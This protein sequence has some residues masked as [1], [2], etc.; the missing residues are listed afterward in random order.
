[1]IL[2]PFVSHLFAIQGL[3][4]VSECRKQCNNLSEH[5]RNKE[6]EYL[7]DKI[8]DLAKNCKNKNITCIEE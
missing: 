7:K 5:L 2:S 8:N 3:K 6:R 1:M 4:Q